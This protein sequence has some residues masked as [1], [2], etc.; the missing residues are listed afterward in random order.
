MNRIADVFARKGKKALIAYVT[1]GYPSI[2]A[3]LNV[4]PLLAESGCDIVELGIPFSDPLADG[5]TIQNASHHAI[6]NGLTPQLCLDIAGELSEKTAVPLVFMTY[7]N[8]IISYGP[9]RFCHASAR[10]GVSGMIIPDLPPDEGAELD[11]L[12]AR[13][14][15]DLI[16]LLPPTATA[17]RAGLIAQ[18]SQGF[19]YLVSVTGVTG[20]RTSL[21]VNLDAAIAN[22]RTITDKP[23]CVGFGISTP[24][25]AREAARP[26]DGVIIGSK[27]IQLME[28]DASY[29]ALKDFIKSVRKSLDE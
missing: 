17:A 1:V 20:A 3:T 28:A 6:Q 16:Y 24:E 15:I 11:R 23:L 8:P 22:L 26:A 2:E 14:G 7:L 10:S 4:V 13:N 5:A 29:G 27:I 9:E 18:K 21:P 12:T 25:Q 19:I